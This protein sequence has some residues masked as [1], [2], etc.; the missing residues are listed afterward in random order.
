MRLHASC[1]NEWLLYSFTLL[2]SAGRTAL[3]KEGQ[4]LCY[5]VVRGDHGCQHHQRAW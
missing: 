1:N 3:D 4:E 2:Q 5:G